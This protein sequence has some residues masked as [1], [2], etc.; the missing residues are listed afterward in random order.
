MGRR[1]SYDT[2]EHNRMCSRN[3]DSFSERSLARMWCTGSLVGEI[4]RNGGGG[5]SLNMGMMVAE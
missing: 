2:L 3:V 1:Y 4:V 5:F